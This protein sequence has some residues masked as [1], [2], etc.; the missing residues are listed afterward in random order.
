[1]TIHITPGKNV[2]IRYLVS[3]LICAIIPYYTTKV[4]RHAIQDATEEEY[5]KDIR[6]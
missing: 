2:Q 3:L 6:P 5:Q 1:M 4:I